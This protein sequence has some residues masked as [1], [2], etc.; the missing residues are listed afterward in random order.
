MKKLFALSIIAVM[1]VGCNTV[2][3]F[4]KDIEKVGSKMEGAAKK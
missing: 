1:L 4:G 3:G 2:A